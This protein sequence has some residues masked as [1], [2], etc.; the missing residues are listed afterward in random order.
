MNTK[1]YLIFALLYPLVCFSQNGDASM[2]K[3]WCPTSLSG[4]VK[5][6]GQYRYEKGTTNQ[7]YNYQ[8]SPVF[9]GGFLLNSSSYFYHPNLLT[10]DLSAEYNPEKRQDI[11][12]VV[13][14]QSEVK[15]VKRLNINTVMFKQKE[16]TIGAFANFDESYTNRENLSNLK[17]NSTSWGTNLLYG[18]KFLPVSVSYQQGVTNEKEVQT[19]R[20]FNTR[21][22]NFNSTANKSFG[23][24][25]NNELSYSHNTFSRQDFNLTE[26]KNTTDII[27]L[28][29]NMYFDEQRN[30]NFNSN[31][32]GTKQIGYDTYNSFQAFENYT[33]KLPKNFIV[34]A[35]Y[36]F[37]NIKRDLQDLKQN[38][39]NFFL[40][41]HLFKSLFTDLNYEY[42]RVNQSVYQETNN[43]AGF[44]L[45]YEKDIPKG[46]LSLSYNF[47]RLNQNHKSA[48]VLLQI[49]NEPY[50][51][52][53][54]QI[55]LLNKPYIVPGSVV[56]KDFTGTIVYQEFFDYTIIERNNY[57]EIQRIPGGQ[58]PNN[59][60]VYVDY[61]AN[62]PGSYEYDSDFQHFVASVTL[63]DQFVEVY[64][65][66]SKQDYFNLQTSDFQT[67]NYFNQNIIGSRF[68]YKF[69]S[70]GVEYDDYNS[71]I[72][73]YRL[74]RFFM[75]LQGS[76]ENRL[77]FSLNG[78]LRN[79]QMIDNQAN[80]QYSDLSGNVAYLFNA[81]TKLN[82]EVG[83]RK[84][85][86]EGIDLNLLTFR[87]EFTAN[88]R[89]LYFKVGVEMYRRLYLGEKVDFVGANIEV[90]RKFN[91]NR[92]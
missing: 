15:T 24:R 1:W 61:I 59:A 54:G 58:I 19:N 43:K 60:I 87:S 28:N 80:Q 8:K 65:R 73:P 53:D 31:I 79:Y 90:V 68:E 36:N 56:V 23:S 5:L 39:L 72:I 89:Q 40:R 18:N 50:T 26:I 67:L 62:Q 81:Q 22:C 17:V 34:G 33:M 21:Q 63:F 9:Y 88:Y 91:W 71:N 52:T 76:F 11:Y 78:N 25:D 69:A 49:L 47:S 74:L 4:A 30:M 85:A 12:L 13:P 45:R 32:S 48:S 20:V 86:G 57:L 46:H 77:L 37:Y 66:W 2:C 42:G 3:V 70:V 6:G 64:Y 7:V 35:N 44:G 38:N 27:N 10:L 51:L 82:F 29:N 75:L 92:R 55:A 84:Q 83:Y 14:D 16:V 41:H